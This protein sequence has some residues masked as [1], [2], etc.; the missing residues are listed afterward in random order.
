M[1]DNASDSSTQIELEPG[2]LSLDMFPDQTALEN[3]ALVWGDRADQD[4]FA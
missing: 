1:M 3:Y 4:K 2:S